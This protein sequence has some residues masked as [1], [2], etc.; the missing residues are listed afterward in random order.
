MRLSSLLLAISST[1]TLVSASAPYVVQWNNTK[2]YGP[3]GPWPVVT[4][5]VGTQENGVGL[6]TVDLHPGGI[7]QSMILTE[8]FCNGDNDPTHCPAAQAGLYNINGSHNVL[9]NITKETGLVWEWGSDSAFNIS[10]SAN[11]VVDV[12]TLRGVRGQSMTVGN[13]TIAAVDSSTIALPDRTNHSIQVGHLSLGAPGGGGQPFGN[14]DGETFAGHAAANNIIPSNSFG[15]HYGSSSL[16]QVGSLVWGGYDQSRV[17]G[18]AAAFDLTVN[19]EMLPS[20]LDVQIGVETGSSPFANGASSMIGLLKQNASFQ[21][22]QPTII[23]PVVPYL[24]MSPETCTAIVQNL[25]VTLEPKVGLYLWNT[26]DPNYKRIVQSPA[27]LAFVFQNAGVGNLTIR[28]PFPLL[29][30][31]LEGPIVA[32]P[33]P[34]F[35][36]RP[37]HANDNSGNYVLG[38]AFLQAAFIGMNWEQNKFFMAQAPGPG[39]GASNVQSIGPNDTYINSDPIDNFAPTWAKDWTVLSSTGNSSSLGSGTGSGTGLSSGA[40]AG[41]GVGV[42]VGVLAIVATSVFCCLRRRKRKIVLQKDDNALETEPMYRPFHEKDTRPISHDISTALPHEMGT[43]SPVQY[44]H[45][46]GAGHDP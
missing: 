41:I 5:H 31:T 1:T 21:G 44:P 30:L 36:C 27:Y 26:G 4:V 12:M 40:K 11:N 42:A 8:A 32:T 37:F 9:R 10:G 23:N 35:P 45:E 15:L 6:S 3:D 25:P 46:L 22:V 39:V 28:V 17:L 29:N 33:Q 2:S 24:F 13:S 34:Y 20:L 7:W 18:D 19:N 43:D 14:V 16:N 38:K